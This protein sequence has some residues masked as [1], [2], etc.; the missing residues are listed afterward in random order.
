MLTPEHFA[1]FERCDA[2]TRAFY[3]LGRTLDADPRASA[4]QRGRVQLAY[5]LAHARTAPVPTS[6][7]SNSYPLRSSI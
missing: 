2:E 1:E 6:R 7:P 4:E 3:A 5:A